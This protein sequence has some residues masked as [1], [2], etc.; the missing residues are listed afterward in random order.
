MTVI[1]ESPREYLPT[2][3]RFLY[4]ILTM[5]LI[6]SLM[7]IPLRTSLIRDIWFC[8]SSLSEE[9]SANPWIYSMTALIEVLHIS[10]LAFAFS[11]V[12]K[13]SPVRA[14]VVSAISILVCFCLLVSLAFVCCYGLISASICVYA[15]LAAVFAAFGQFVMYEEVPIEF[16]VRTRDGKTSP[17]IP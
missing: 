1:G 16:V 9:P 3:K 10:F 15:G 17:L 8:V 12:Y 4:G 6:L 11:S 7:S 5:V 14:L 13:A 2:F